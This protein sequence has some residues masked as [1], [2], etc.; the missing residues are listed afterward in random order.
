MKDESI[1]IH[2]TTMGISNHTKPGAYPTANL[3]IWYM[4]PFLIGQVKN[5]LNFSNGA[6]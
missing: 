1:Q 5:D 3:K 4:F 2:E 6:S